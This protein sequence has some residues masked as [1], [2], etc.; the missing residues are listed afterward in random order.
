M[1]VDPLSMTCRVN[2][3]K[4]SFRMRLSELEY[5]ALEFPLSHISHVQIILET[6]INIGVAFH[7]MIAIF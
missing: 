2:S 1:M 6:L 5:D 7:Y 4:V 3:I